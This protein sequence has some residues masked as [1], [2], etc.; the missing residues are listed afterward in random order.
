[1][2]NQSSTKIRHRPRKNSNNHGTL[3]EPVRAR[4]QRFYH[5]WEK[6]ILN[7]LVLE[8]IKDWYAI[9]FLHW[10]LETG[11]VVTQAPKDQLK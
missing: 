1:M 10:P 4:I 2:L 11:S 6:T 9:D 5:V 7:R 3:L 8:M